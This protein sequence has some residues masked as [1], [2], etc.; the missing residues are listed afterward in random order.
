MPN[1]RALAQKAAREAGVDPRLFQSLI[2]KGERSWKGWQTS[3]SGAQGPSQLMP[4]TAQ[5]LASKYGIDP[6]SYYGNLLGGAYY[7]REQL[8]AF[9]GN[10]RKAVA[11][12]NAGPGNV[13]KYGGIPPF[14]ETRRYVRNVLG[15]V[16]EVIPGPPPRPGAPRAGVPAAAMPD[17][18]AG[19]L[20]T[21]ALGGSSVGALRSLL[22]APAHWT[23]THPGRPALPAGPNTGLGVPLPAG[24]RGKVLVAPGANRKG[25]GIKPIV[26]NFLSTLGVPVTIG[27]GTNHSR[28]TVNGH[29][30][31]HWD[32]GASDIPASGEKLIRL[33]R[34]ALIAAGMP[35]AQA[36]KQNGGLYNLSWKGHRVQVIFATTEGGNHWDHVHVGIR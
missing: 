31:D 32:G 4:G 30:S 16:Q 14:S 20:K 8:Q 22:A 1:P 19:A 12:Y 6:H 28:M 25:V 2:F 17:F 21:I 15:G 10:R 35:R 24:Q 27:T 33:G 11:A 36:M 23:A 26:F 34:R 29:V 5:G 9:K 18:G 7:L 3:P 13:E